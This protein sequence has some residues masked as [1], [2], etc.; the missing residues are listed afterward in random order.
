[1]LFL[2][3]QPGAQELLST[4]SHR[5]LKIDLWIFNED[6]FQCLFLSAWL[7]N[8]KRTS[9]VLICSVCVCVCVIAQYMY[10][11]SSWCVHATLWQRDS[12]LEQTE[13]ESTSWEWK[14]W[15]ALC[16]SLANAFEPHTELS[17][18]PSRGNNFKFFR[19]VPTSLSSR[20][21]LR[22]GKTD[23]SSSGS[24]IFT[25]EMRGKV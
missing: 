5:L 12:E 11:C 23:F 3:N 21:T 9:S 7:N 20:Q 4:I 14:S 19:V 17:K 2:Y 15:F 25:A 10:V 6:S 13:T 1:M 24:V 18:T 16:H 22:G 8:S